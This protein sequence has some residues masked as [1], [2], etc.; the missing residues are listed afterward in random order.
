MASIQNEIEQWKSAVKTSPKAFNPIVV[1]VASEADFK[2]FAQQLLTLRGAAIRAG[3]A[4]ELRS[5]GK[6]GVYHATLCSSEGFT[7]SLKH[8][9][10]TRAQAVTETSRE[11][12]RQIEIGSACQ[13]F[14]DAA[15]KVQREQGYFTDAAVSRL[16]ADWPPSTVSGRRNDVA[17]TGVTID[18]SNYV[19]SEFAQVVD[20]FSRRTVKA[21]QL[22][23]EMARPASNARQIEMF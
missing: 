12:Y 7:I 20:P 3:Y 10:Q 5:W 19:V 17:K 14:A 13:R 18:G 9:Q 23:E 6:E 8:R 16:L 11:S 4:C 1:W 2:Q 21:W 15:M 22:V